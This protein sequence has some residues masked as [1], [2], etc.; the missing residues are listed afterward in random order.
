M[1]FYCCTYEMT[2]DDLPP[3]TLSSTVKQTAPITLTAN[4]Q[5]KKCGS[6][7]ATRWT[8]QRCTLYM[9]IKLKLESTPFLNA[10]IIDSKY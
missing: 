8:M 10:V 7:T 5:D 1:H 6:T 9:H 2:G 4:D 3:L